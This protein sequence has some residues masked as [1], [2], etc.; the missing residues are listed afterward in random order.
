MPTRICWNGQPIGE[1][2]THGKT[3]DKA[4]F[5]ALRPVDRLR[6]Y[7]LMAYP[8][9]RHGRLLSA[10]CQIPRKNISNFLKSDLRTG[11]VVK[12]APGWYCAQPIAESELLDA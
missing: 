11:V 5:R 4:A 9:A 8:H 3:L 7:L 1:Q 10:V 6:A 2:T 12:V